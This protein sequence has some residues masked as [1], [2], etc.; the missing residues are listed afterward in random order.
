MI[1]NRSA[2]IGDVIPSLIYENVGEA[3]N[4]LCKTFGFTERFRYGADD[5]PSGALLIVG[6]GSVFLTGPRVSEWADQTKFQPP[7]R[8]ESSHFV[9]IRIENV[10]SHYEYSLQC[11][12]RILH[13]PETYPFG[14]RQYSV[15]D[16]EG[17]RWTF[18]QS[19]AD[20][21]PKEWGG[22]TG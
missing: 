2:A 17:H 6:T 1:V 19:V 9:H 7:K 12:A 11:K 13:L 20:V 14:E 3:S 10:D 8:G 22:R 18:T 16:L 21:A 4:W 15:E 5:N